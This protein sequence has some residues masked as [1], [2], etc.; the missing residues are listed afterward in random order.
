MQIG[1]CVP[2][3]QYEQAARAGYDYVEFPGWEIASLHCDEVAALA[4]KTRAL[5]VPCLRLNAYCKGLPAI[6]GQYVDREKTRIYA[7]ELMKKAALL[8]VACVGVGAPAARMLPAGFDLAEADRQCEEFFRITGTAAAAYGLDVLV[9]A[10]P[11]Q[12]CSY[13]NT[14]EQ[15]LELVQHLAMDH[16]WMVVDLYNM[17]MQGESW[18][19]VAHYLPWT[20]HIHIS[21]R[22]EGIARCAYRRGDEGS[23]LRAFRTIV[24]AGYDGTVSLEADASELVHDAGKK[25]LEIMRTAYEQAKAEERR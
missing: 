17:E 22:G 5:G 3:A 21:T 18:D 2:V 9:E 12:M 15:A 14:A 25:A 8:D 1:C 10:V 23:C 20:R 4:E 19:T 13:L 11:Y 16:V 7:E 24:N 6:V